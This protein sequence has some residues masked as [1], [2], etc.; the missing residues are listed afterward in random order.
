M[1]GSWDEPGRVKHAEARVA[2][3][4]CGRVWALA[5]AGA[6]LAAT[7]VVP[8][9]GPTVRAEGEGP[10]GLAVGTSDGHAV[11]PRGRSERGESGGSV[12]VG[13]V[14]D[15]ASWSEGP[16]APGS[17]RDV[18]T[19]P[20]PRG[21]ARQDAPRGLESTAAAPASPAPVSRT[22]LLLSVMATTAP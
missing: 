14:I 9:W 15:A 6:P 2:R 21:Q 7:C 19:G 20:G 16:S 10:G 11:G 13:A 5:E 4:R 8:S 3:R 22:S 12:V 1:A 18:V 17:R